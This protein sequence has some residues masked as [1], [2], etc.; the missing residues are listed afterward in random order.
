ME[1]NLYHKPEYI[2][3]TETV[4]FRKKNNRYRKEINAYFIYIQGYRDGKPKQSHLHYARS[5][6]KALLPCCI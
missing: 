5:E 4:T 6:H 3:C 1:N 2:I